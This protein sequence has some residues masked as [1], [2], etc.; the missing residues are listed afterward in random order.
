MAAIAGP[1]VQMIFKSGSTTGDPGD[2]RVAFDAIGTFTSTT[3]VL[4]SGRTT[5][6]RDVSLYLRT[7][8]PRSI[9]TLASDAAFAVFLV[10]SVT[11]QSWGVEYAVT[12]LSGVLPA[13]GTRLAV[14][15]ALPGQ[16]VTGPQGA[17]GPQ[18]PAGLRGPAGEKGARGDSGLRGLVGPQG[19]GGGEPGPQGEQG[20]P[21]P[22]G[23]TGPQGA[24]GDKG[25]KGD[26]G[27]SYAATSGSSV[28]LGSGSK[29]F[30]T[31]SGLPY[32]A[33]ARVR[34]ASTASPTLEWM[35]GVVTGYSGTTLTVS[36]TS[37]SGT[38]TR[39][40]WNISL[41]GEP[42]AAGPT[43]ASGIIG[44]AFKDDEQTVKNTAT[45]TEIFST[46]IAGGTFGAHS[47]VRVKQA[48]SPTATADNVTLT[49]KV[50]L[51][52]TTVATFVTSFWSGGP[53]DVVMELFLRGKGDASHQC[54]H[55]L[56]SG[57][58]SGGLW[59]DDANVNTATDKALSITAQWSAANN[60]NDLLVGQA[61]A[62]LVRAA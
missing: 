33:G 28:A 15:L 41:A 8:T 9:L 10:S 36:A 59:F 2:G 29:T 3:R 49:F 12:P 19:P 25:D 24:K 14:W 40:S 30:T 48:M 22:T 39:S 51:G 7:A 13:L 16:T 27:A 60:G 17:A 52:G 42:G 26:A 1:G 61:T 46:T 11:V 23:D 21:G 62:E 55:L 58:G 56:L 4:I 47:G 37:F 35:E 45:E 31:Q 6:N 54:G 44:I 32:V 53:Y 38:G 57:S 5:D 20:P 34:I 43:G 18:G 50:K